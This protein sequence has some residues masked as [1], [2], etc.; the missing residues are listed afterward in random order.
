MKQGLPL[1][2]TQLLSSD[3]WK[4]GPIVQLPD[5]TCSARAEDVVMNYSWVK[6]VVL[7]FRDRVPSGFFLTDIFLFLDRLWYGK[8]LQPLQP[9]DTKETLAGEEAKKIKNLIGCLRALWRSSTLA[10]CL[11][12]MFVYNKTFPKQ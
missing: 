5:S 1:P 7:R 10:T 4:G 11:A 9:E 3:S 2:V 12:P 6:P 8:L